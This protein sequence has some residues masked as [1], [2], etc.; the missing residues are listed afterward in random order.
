[1]TR[2]TKISSAIIAAVITV[3]VA[4]PPLFSY[5][6]LGA[7]NALMSF[8]MAP[9]LANYITSKMVNVDS[10]GNLI[11]PVASGKY[12]SVSAGDLNFLTSGQ[13]LGIQEATAG[14][15]CSGTLTANATTPVVTSTTCARTGSR[16]FLNRTSNVNVVPVYVSAISD[17]VSFSV[18]GQATDTGTYNWVIFHEA[19]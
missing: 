11:L 6:A 12:A 1:M 18:T 19:P 3:Y 14:S 17:G 7:A 16:I 4:V 13:T 15:A 2:F 5:A 8:G 10:S 9:E